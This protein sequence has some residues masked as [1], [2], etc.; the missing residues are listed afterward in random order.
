MNAV[1]QKRVLLVGM[2]ADIGSNLLY[3]SAASCVAYPITDVLTNPIESEGVGAADRGGLEELKARLI[4]ANPQLIDRIT[5]DHSQSVL[6]IDGRTFHIHFRD[7]ES[8]LSSLGLFDLAILAT[9]RKHIRSRNHLHRLEAIARVVIGVAENADLP[10]LYPALMAA[11]PQHFRAGHKVDSAE[12]TGSFA[13]GSCQ[14]VGWTTGLRVLADYCAT[15]GVN[16]Q[17]ILIHS[18]VDI[19]HPD[20]AS[21]NFGTKRIGARTEDPRDNLRPGASQVADSMLRFQPATTANNVSLRTLTQP[22]GYQIQRFFVR[23][24]AV[25]VDDLTAAARA[26]SVAE[27]T[28]IRVVDTPVG[29]RAYASLACGIVL[30]ATRQH[31]S[32]RHIGDMIEVVFQAYVHNT[33]G[34]CATILSA[35][36]RILRGEAVTL[37]DS[38]H[39]TMIG[40]KHASSIGA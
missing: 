28:L 22:P 36:D 30:L 20:T 26:L 37:I 38:H 33:L 10:A 9:S 2:G 21:S 14:C 3:L 23:G 5:T 16:L 7:L 29:S 4:L 32:V 35:T 34:Y 25:S 17:D 15:Q 31:A 1:H 40:G 18:E 24:L 11:A 8:D 39:M 27:P 13:M 6:G 19:V 12:M